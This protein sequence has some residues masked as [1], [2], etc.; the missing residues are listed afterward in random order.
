M[1]HESIGELHGFGTSRSEFTRDD[2]FTTFGTGIHDESEHTV[3][4]PESDKEAKSGQGRV[5]LEDI[6]SPANIQTSLAS[7][8]QMR[9]DAHLRTAKPPNNLYLKLSA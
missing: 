9:D 6:I 4:G 5:R 1:D 8:R 2:D 3:T 7:K